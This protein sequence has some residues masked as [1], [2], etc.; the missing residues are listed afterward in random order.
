ME[1]L[2]TPDFWI[3]LVMIYV[4]AV[5]LGWLPTGGYVPIDESVTGWLRSMAMPA[6]ALGLLRGVVDLASRAFNWMASIHR[7]TE[8]DSEGLDLH[9]FPLDMSSLVIA[10]TPLSPAHPA[11]H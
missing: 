6:L 5:S 11:H 2:S 3:G 9:S 7:T 4:F 8:V 10:A 1:F